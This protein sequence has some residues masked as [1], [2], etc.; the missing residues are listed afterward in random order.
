MKMQAYIDEIKLEITG[1]I[2][3]LEIDDTVLKQI[4]NSAMRELQRYI[5][6]TKLITIPY[7][8]C[9]D[10]S[11]YKVNAVTKVFRANSQGTTSDKDNYSTDPLQLSF[12][13][14]ASGGNMYNFNDYVNRYASW[15]TIQQISNTTS[16]DL[17]FYYED[18]EKKLYINTTMNTG[19]NVSIEYVPRY[20]KVEDITSDYWI[21]ILMRLS[22]ALTKTTV[23]RIRSR[24]TQSNALW[25][26]DGPEL[27]QQGQAEL[28]EIRQ[29]LQANTQLIYPVD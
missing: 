18:A 20:D 19:A 6:S 22:K 2:L 4:V 13:Q 7:S 28:A 16:T 11:K 26:Q 12:Y 24:F 17:A 9:I 25:T 27:L 14:L 29:H 5:C 3:E 21:D 8:K 10:L 1:G 23:G 15:N